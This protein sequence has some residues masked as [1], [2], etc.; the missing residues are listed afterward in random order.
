MCFKAGNPWV[1]HC[2]VLRINSSKFLI[3]TILILK[4]KKKNTEQHCFDFITLAKPRQLKSTWNSHFLYI[5]WTPDLVS[6]SKERTLRY[7]MH[8]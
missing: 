4:K 7:H 6:E 3:P 8:V 1:F 2:I 5:G